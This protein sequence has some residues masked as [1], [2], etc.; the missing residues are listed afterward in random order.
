MMEHSK[1]LKYGIYQV[2]SN[3]GSKSFWIGLKVQFNTTNIIYFSIALFT[4]S[5]VDISYLEVFP[6][7]LL[8][9][10]SPFGTNP[11][12]LLANVFAGT[13]M[14]GLCQ[15]Q[16]Y[17]GQGHRAADTPESAKTRQQSGTCSRLRIP[18]FLPFKRVFPIL[19]F[20][21]QIIIK[22]A[23]HILELNK[24]IILQDFIHKQNPLQF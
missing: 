8:G 19:K 4:I 24:N 3:A 9:K 17:G 21:S 7:C 12:C 18:R 6:A 1:I 23:A 16:S 13:T 20:C 15:K 11:L 5:D 14:S 10:R 22:V 2:R